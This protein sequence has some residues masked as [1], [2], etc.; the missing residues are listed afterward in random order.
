MKKSDQKK[1]RAAL[2]KR[3]RA[4]GRRAAAVLYPSSPTEFYI[5][6]AREYPLVECLINSRWDEGGL[7]SITLARRQPNSNIVFGNYLVDYYCL[8]LKNTMC[9][10]DFTVTEYQTTIRNKA[11]Q[12]FPDPRPVECPPD[13]AHEIIYGAIEYAARFGFKPQRDFRWSQYILEPAD[14]FARVHNVQFGKDG[15]PFFIN[16]PYDNAEAIVRQLERTAGPGNYD[17][18]TMIGPPDAETFMPDDDEP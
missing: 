11:Y 4:K 18:L 2:Q 8:G 16:G 17:Y 9:N 10:A 14:H 6:H 1:Q 15:K 7:T 5:R 3:A 13:L 12:A